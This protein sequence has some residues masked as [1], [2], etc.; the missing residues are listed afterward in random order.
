MEFVNITNINDL[1]NAIRERNII[2]RERLAFEKEMF[3]FNKQINLDIAKANVDTA[4]TT[5]IAIEKIND[6]CKHI[7]IL[8]GND[9]YL[10]KEIDELKQ[11]F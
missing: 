10:K 3:E 8:A 2:E 1:A 6:L 11:R 7:E 9:A 5:A 4:N